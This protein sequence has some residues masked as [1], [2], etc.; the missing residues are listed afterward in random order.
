M[1]SVSSNVPLESSPWFVGKME[2][3]NAEQFL[4]EV[5]DK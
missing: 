4:M 1:M 5:R 3:V 2:R